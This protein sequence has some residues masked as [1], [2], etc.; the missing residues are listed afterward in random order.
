MAYK[1]YRFDNR[2]QQQF[3]KDIKKSHKYE[4]EIAVRL[5]IFHFQAKKFWPVIKATGVDSTGEF[6]K[7]NNEVHGYPDFEIDG[8]PVEITRSDIIC[9]SSFHQKCN[10]IE[11]AIENKYHLV[12]VNGFTK[13]LEPNFIY[14]SDELIKEYTIKAESKYGKVLHP[15]A[16]GTTGKAAYRYDLF[17]FKDIFNKLPKLNDYKI[18]KEYKC[19]LDSTN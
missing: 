10:K 11:K 6:I 8:Q 5:G 1:N 13:E 16:N 18:P 14:L 17:W 3:Q 19:I 15:G 2:T 7:N 4:A 12:F 9:K